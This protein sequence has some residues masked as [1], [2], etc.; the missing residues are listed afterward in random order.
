MLWSVGDTLARERN[1]CSMTDAMTWGA[2]YSADDEGDLRSVAL[3]LIAWEQIENS[4]P[5]D[6][7][8]STARRIKEHARRIAEWNRR[9]AK[10]NP[11]FHWELNW[12]EPGRV[13]SEV[14]WHRRY[15]WVSDGRHRLLAARRMGSAPVWAY[16]LGYAFHPADLRP[17]DRELM[18]TDEVFGRPEFDTMTGRA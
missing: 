1:A 15:G 3:G 7:P 4:L 11:R 12:T 6:P 10:D 13:A 16:V 8:R 2:C 14:E 5:P 18:P 17:R 9:D